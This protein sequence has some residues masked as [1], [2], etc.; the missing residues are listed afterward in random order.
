MCPKHCILTNEELTSDNNSKAHVIPSALGGRLKPLDI[1]SKEANRILGEKFDLPLIQALQPIATQLNISRDRGQNQPF[2]MIDGSGK[3]YWFS[4][5]KPL[6]LTRPE[7]STQ[8][9]EKGTQVFVS[10]RN[11]KEA[12]TLLGKIIAQYP[13]LDI[14]D[15]MKHAV[16]QKV[17]PNGMLNFEIPFGPPIIF[18]AAYVSASIFAA[19]KGYD[20][21]PQFRNFVLKYDPEKPSMPPDTFYFIPEHAWISAKG[22][23]THIMSLITDAKKGNML[24]YIELFNTVCV[25]VRIPF[26]GNIDA[27]A[28]YGIDVLTGQEVQVLINEEYVSG[29]PF[30]AT[31]KPGDKVLRDLMQDKLARIIAISQELAFNAQM[32]EILF[33][34]FGSPD[35]RP[36]LAVD[37]AKLV[38]EIARFIAIE[39]ER[40]LTTVEHKKQASKLFEELCSKMTS[41]IP[42]HL[43]AEFLDLIMPHQHMMAKLANQ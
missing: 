30:S 16:S 22:D 29:L 11:Q 1:L 3:V 18:P 8:E 9:T 24:I 40:P 2:K 26:D 20:P 28:S 7:F 4:F 23:V 38:E 25:G 34:A 37:Y 10:A 41:R 32:K 14:D 35:G 43:R 36:L 5:D 27:C 6:K 21:H 19:Y 12:R 39:L 33:R 17:W 31:H 13:G 42:G 15:L